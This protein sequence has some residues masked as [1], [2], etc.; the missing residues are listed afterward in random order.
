M[1]I[2]ITVMRFKPDDIS[3]L[4]NLMQAVIRAFLSMETET[5]MF[6]DGDGEG[7]VAVTINPPAPRFNE[8]PKRGRLGSVVSAESQD[9]SRKVIHTLA[10]PSKDILK[11]MREGMRRSHAA[12]MDLSGYRKY[13]GPSPNISSDIGSIR[14]RLKMTMS[15]FD[16]V[17]ATLVNSN[18][19]PPSSIEESDVVELFIF[20]RHVREAAAAV[21]KLLD[22]VELMQQSPS[23]PEIHMPSYP[24]QKALHRTNRQVRHDRGGLTAGSYHST[25]SD[26]AKILDKIKSQDYRPPPRTRPGTPVADEEE[27]KGSHPTMDAEA[28]GRTDKEKKGRGYRIWRVLHRLQGFETRYAFKVCLVTSLLSVP[29]Y[30]KGRNWWDKYEVW[31]AVSASWIMIHPRVG[32]NIQDLVTRA[33]AAVLGAVWAGTAHAAGDGN[34][35]VLAVFAAI[36][37][38]PMLYRYIQSSH[39]VFAL[40][41]IV[42]ILC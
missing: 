5:F 32:G 8:A 12:L 39:P 2:D 33:F 38:I 20:A 22:K 31:W 11:S 29:S 10:G 1:R 7:A 24:L 16:D 34:P 23:W 13:L 42:T 27:V 3:D 35:F 28:D 30:L 40:L 4:R 25:F 18:E 26:I 15:A 6:H 17:E 19:L 36:F 37:M 9:A 14:T 21:H 41:P